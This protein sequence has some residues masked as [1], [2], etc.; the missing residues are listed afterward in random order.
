VFT[1][2][3]ALLWSTSLRG[4]FITGHDIQLEYY[5]FQI[6]NAAQHWSMATFRDPYNACLSITILP[7][8]LK[9]LTGIGAIALYKV[10]YQIWFALGVTGVWL[11]SRRYLSAAAAFVGAF[12]FITFPTFV[13]DMPM[14]VRQEVAFTFFVALLLAL[15]NR[16]LRPGVRRMLFVSLIAGMVLSHYST[17]FV[18][19][20]IMGGV[21]VWQLVA[22]RFHR[23]TV[24]DLPEAAGVTLGVVVMLLVSTVF[25]TGIYTKT[26]SNITATLT[27]AVKSL[28]TILQPKEAT[29]SS[30][31]T[32]IKS[33]NVPNQV[34]LNNYVTSQHDSAEALAA[35][36]GGFYANAAGYVLKSV[37]QPN[38]PITALGRLV[39]KLGVGPGTLVALGKQ[40]YALALQGLILAGTGI[41]YLRRRALKLD[42]GLRAM[43]VVGIVFLG[44]Q[45]LLAF[46]D[47]GLFRLLQQ[48]LVFLVIPALLGAKQLFA[49]LRIRRERVW[50]SII[51]GALALSFLVLS[52]FVS[53]LLGGSVAAL[54]LSNSGFYYDAYYTS[55]QDISTFAWIKDNYP[56]GYPINTDSFT[57]MKLLA[58]TGI[59]ALDG[60]T[61]DQITRQ[62]YVVLTG[63]NVTEDR[64][65][66]Y[67]S[68]NG[69][70]L[71]YQYPTQFL[72][73]DKN[74]IYS[75]NSTRVY[76]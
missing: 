3:L 21:Y 35:Q 2:S 57:R 28:P 7:T 52:G 44:L 73:S 63:I 74:L 32:L 59:T 64:V 36:A 48:E 4:F 34:Q 65:G 45:A 37:N 56:A 40:A 49:W 66:L 61:P 10:V 76:H 58:N 43:A 62:S 67:Y 19:L 70:L 41:V 12:I 5:V 9:S 38:L 6:T 11:L 39:S 60:I 31:Y 16:N 46:I 18:A 53:E 1:M 22:R 23:A 72:N 51:M 20:A 71:F 68:V 29:D 69:Q 8:I 55:N 54:P 17:T 13:T 26:G 33:I 25:W 27:N 50:L 30:A 75:T 47:Y 14:L 15:Y 24:F 42:S